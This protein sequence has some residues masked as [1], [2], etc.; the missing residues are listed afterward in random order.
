MIALWW[1]VS[2]ALVV[3]SALL[4]A[5]GFQGKEGVLRIG[6]PREAEGEEPARPEPLQSAS[7]QGED[8][9][10]QPS[11]Q[12]PDG[13]PGQPGEAQG[14]GLPGARP[15]GLPQ[16]WETQPRRMNLPNV[17]VGAAGVVV[18]LGAILIFAI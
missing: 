16:D 11:G 4:L 17:A 6:Q 3:L 7:T 13:Q 15:Q 12:P 1:L 14:Q 5:A 9:S 10:G 8:A 2:L 18:G